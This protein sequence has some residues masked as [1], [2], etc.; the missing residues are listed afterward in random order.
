MTKKLNRILVIISFTALFLVF[1]C[2]EEYEK[3]NNIN[4][5]NKNFE[6]KYKSFNELMKEQK[7]SSS[8]KKVDQKLK[9]VN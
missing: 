4:Q 9:T 5:Q 3:E 8:Y 7:F 6:I 2:T 1:G